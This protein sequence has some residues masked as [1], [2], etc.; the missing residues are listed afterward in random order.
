MSERR[1]FLGHTPSNSA[2]IAGLFNSRQFPT[3]LLP[4]V[5]AM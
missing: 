4:V 2:T 3:T 1:A 5:A